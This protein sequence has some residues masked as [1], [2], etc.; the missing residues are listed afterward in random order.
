MWKVRH[1]MIR[2]SANDVYSRSPI[3]ASI[4]SRRLELGWSQARLADA[5]HT[6]QS[7]ISSILRGQSE[8]TLLMLEKM[9]SAVGLMLVT[10]YV[11]G[12]NTWQANSQSD[13]KTS[14]P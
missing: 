13:R 10:T 9:C 4:D 12:R 11:P 5:C 6:A 1:A 3:I 2:P 8:P 7:H 14:T